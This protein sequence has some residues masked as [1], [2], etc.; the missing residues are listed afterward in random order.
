[1]GL[2]LGLSKI[3]NACSRS[4]DGCLA[5]PSGG[6]TSRRSAGERLKQRGVHEKEWSTGE[7]VVAIA[8][9]RS[10][11]RVVLA[12]KKALVGI[13]RV[14]IDVLE[15]VAVDEHVVRPPVPAA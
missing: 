5:A 7:S 9:V 12:A 1:M 8:A 11:E 15:V 14:E 10:E 3:G 6:A 2:G 13:A 4:D